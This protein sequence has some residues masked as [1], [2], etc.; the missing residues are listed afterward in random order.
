[1]PHPIANPG[2]D[3]IDA[4][5]NPTETKCFYYLHDNNREIHC[6]E[7]YEDHLENIKTYLK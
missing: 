2:I 6:A 3:A 5:L 1:P 4:V 7:T